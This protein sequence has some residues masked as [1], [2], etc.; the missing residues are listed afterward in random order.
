MTANVEGWGDSAHSD[1]TCHKC[2][3]DSGVRGWAASMFVGASTLYVHLTDRPEVHEIAAVVPPE[4]CVACHGGAWQDQMFAAMHPLPT[5]R[6]DACHRASYHAD[7][8]PV[9]PEVVSEVRDLAHGDSVMCAECH[10][11][12]QMLRADIIADPRDDAAVA[13]EG[14]G[15]G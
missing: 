15:E 14:T 13:V 11:R 10:T 12:R 4:R 8:R 9:Y 5:S 2:H 6:C 1:V 7:D 3:A